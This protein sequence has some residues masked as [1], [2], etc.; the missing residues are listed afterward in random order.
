MFRQKHSTTDAII[1]LKD[2]IKNETEKRNY[3][4][5][6][7]VDFQNAFDIVNHHTLLKKLE[8]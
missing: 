8:Y 6:I 4:C 1:N 3:S 5:G 7:F 2:K